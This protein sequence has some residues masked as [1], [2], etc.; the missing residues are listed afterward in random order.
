LSFTDKKRRT[1]EHLVNVVGGYRRLGRRRGRGLLCW[2]RRFD[3]Y[4]RHLRR[5]LCRRLKL[6]L[7]LIA[8]LLSCRG[9]VLLAWLRS[10]IFPIE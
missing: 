5:Y 4:R 10:R 2:P 6:E 8:D 3:N 1:S 9:E 7:W